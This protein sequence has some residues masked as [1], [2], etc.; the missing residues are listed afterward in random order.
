MITELTEE[1]KA[2]MPEYVQKWIKIGTAND[3][4][5]YD[6]TKEIID[7]FRDVINMKTDVPL[8]LAENPIE[9]WVMCCLIKHNVPLDD[10]NAE[11]KEVFNGN[12]KKW[13]I[14]SAILPYQ[15]G[16]F[17]A[18]VFSFYNYILNELDIEIDAD[19]LEKYRKWEKTS[20]TGCIYPLDDVTVVCQKPLYIH[21][22]EDNVLHKDGGPALEYAGLGE[23]KIYAL[24][25][26]TVPQWLAETDAEHL[27]LEKYNEIDNA[28]VKAEFVRKVGVERFLDKG[29]KIDTFENYDQEENPWWWKSEYEIYDMAFLFSNL[30][31]APYLKMKNIT[32]EIYHLEGVSPACRTLPD[33]LKERF[34]G[35]EMRIVEIS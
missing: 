23:F 2:K 16:S 35:K 7:G 34:G 21:L 19:L 15:S 33:A 12:P 3:R 10:L 5:D 14:P 31:Y 4:L 26:I 24:N 1:Q 11:M 32:T 22:N 17:F 27:D 9:A 8:I 20:E 29:T 30:E 25:G 6:K 13:E 28:D 18:S